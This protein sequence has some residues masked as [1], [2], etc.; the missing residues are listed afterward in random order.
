MCPPLLQY[1]QMPSL[2]WWEPALS[3]QI[4]VKKLREVEK[5]NKMRSNILVK[6]S[7]RGE[8]NSQTRGIYAPGNSP[9][10]ASVLYSSANWLLVVVVVVFI[11]KAWMKKK[12]SLSV[13]GTA[14]WRNFPEDVS[15]CKTLIPRRRKKNLLVLFLFGNHSSNMVDSSKNNSDLFIFENSIR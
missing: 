2:F 13:W 5:P 3:V 9:P 11:F 6:R 8:G 15:A 14:L 7:S 10:L 4:L 1:Y 12:G